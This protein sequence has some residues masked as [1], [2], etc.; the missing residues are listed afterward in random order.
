MNFLVIYLFMTLLIFYILK[1]KLDVVSLIPTKADLKMRNK[2][3][4]KQAKLKLHMKMCPIWPLLL[5]KEVYDEVQE[6][7]Q[8]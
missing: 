8:S 7:R 5:L 3:N 1:H 4:E 2:I 6:R